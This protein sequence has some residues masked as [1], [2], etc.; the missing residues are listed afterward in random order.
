MISPVRR[1]IV[2]AALGLAPAIALF[3]QADKAKPLDL[4]VEFHSGASYPG[5]EPT[6]S[7]EVHL[8]GGGTLADSE[9]LIGDVIAAE[10]QG[11]NCASVASY[12]ITESDSKK[13]IPISAV[14]PVGRESCNDRPT[15]APVLLVLRDKVDAKTKYVVT[16][17]GFPAGTEIASKAQAFPS[18]TKY[19]FSVLPQAAPSEKLTDGTKRDAGQLSVSGGLPF[20]GH[21][22]AFVSTK[23]LF[24]T[25]EKDTKS[26]F[27][28][29]GGVKHGLFRTWYAPV[30]LSETLQGNQ[31]ASSLSAV[32]DLSGSALVP[33]YWTRHALNNDWIDAPLAPDFA[34]SNK[35]T[36]RF[37]QDV[38]A[39]TKKL[40]VDEYALNPAL[41]IEPFY[42]LPSVCSRYRKWI[43]AKAS[44]KTSR[45]FCL[46]YRIDLGLWY[47]PLD[48]TKAG[49]QKAEGY[50]D[51]SFLIPLS[52]LT[53]EKFQLV[54][55]DKLLNSELT[56][57]YSDSVNAA[58]NYVRSRQWTFGISVIK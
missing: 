32:T 53:F 44:D 12:K 25:D 56:I 18:A 52:N 45:Q 58:N 51:V 31:T 3:G 17:A 29:T 47:L 48:Q 34:I 27:A 43:N 40:P 15:P 49:S 13:Q 39:T 4:T 33:W 16:L 8:N 10:K 26:A 46:G 36:H 55:K 37:D 35:Y 6:A 19:E 2:L 7:I 50:G 24:S 30:Q 41:T 38:T 11:W 1:F 21:S 57:K 23:D 42:L 28:V 20:I 22:P 5:M 54:E 14:M 9:K